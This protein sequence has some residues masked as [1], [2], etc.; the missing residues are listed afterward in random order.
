M[1]LASAR[2]ID[3][4]RRKLRRPLERR[5]TWAVRWYKRRSICHLCKPH[6]VCSPTRAR[7]QGIR[8]CA[9]RRQV[10]TWQLVRR[11]CYVRARET[12]TGRCDSPPK[13]KRAPEAYTWSTNCRA[14]ELLKPL[15]T[16]TMPDGAPATALSR[17][18]EATGP[19]V[20]NFDVTSRPLVL[21]LLTESNPNARGPLWT[22]S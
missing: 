12:A 15:L 14:M 16:P 19:R 4:L 18:S 21:D 3:W 1:A 8:R 20:R 17:M 2:P 7:T 13:R 6:G 9:D 5:R 10:S 11:G 22:K